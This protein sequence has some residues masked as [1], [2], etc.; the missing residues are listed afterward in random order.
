MLTRASLSVALSLFVLGCGDEVVQ[1]VPECDAI[2]WPLGLDLEPHR[3]PPAPEFDVTCVDGWGNA[4]ETREA[5]DTI[6]LPGTGFSMRSPAD[7]GWI[8]NV[9]DVHGW[10]N[11]SEWFAEHQLDGDYGLIRV[12]EDGTTPVWTRT[13]QIIWLFAL[14]DDDDEVWALAFTEDHEASLQ[15]IDAATGELLVE[16]PWTSEAKFNAVYPAREGGGVWITAYIELDD[17][18]LDQVLYRATAP[19]VLDEFARQ[20]TD[21]PNQRPFGGLE[22][23]VDG[24]VAWAPVIGFDVYDAD[25]VVRWSHQEA[26]PAASNADSLLAVSRVPT[27]V[28]RG[29]ALQLEKLA[30]DDGHSLWTRQ[31]RR[32]DVVEP[33]LCGPDDC[34]LNDSGYPQLRPDGGYLVSGTHAYP[35]ATCS[36]QPVVIAVSSDGEAEWGHRVDVCGFGGALTIFDDGAFEIFGMSINADG[37][38]PLGGWI[39]R[40]GA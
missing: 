8:I 4:I 11:W 28:G 13:E 18:K 22:V 37:T 39:R 33:E 34:G 1:I 36:G 32:F 40:F 26:W 38:A 30:L 19:D 31:H 15:V 35:S 20:T 27:G 21:D 3:N 14:I 25:G 16:H 24:G 2:G 23:L 5:S 17:G 10:D 29:R 7:G 12:A 9:H 6:A